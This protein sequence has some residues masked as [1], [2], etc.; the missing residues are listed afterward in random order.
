M[1][2]RSAPGLDTGRLALLLAVL[3]R[4]VGLSLGQRRR[5]RLGR[6][7]ASGSAEPGADLALCLAL[8]SAARRPA[9]ARRPGRL[10]RGRPGRRGPPG[11][12]D[13]RGGW[14]RRP[15][16]GSAG[17]W[18]RVRRRPTAPARGDAGRPRWPRRCAAGLVG[19]R[20]RPPAARV[21]RPAP[22]AGRRRRPRPSSRAS[23]PSR[24]GA[25]EP[26]D[27]RPG[28]RP[29]T[30]RGVLSRPSAP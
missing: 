12:P 22:P 17:P 20:G 27:D 5:L 11:G 26:A 8:A 18:S 19:R 15:G 25:G 7:R 21:R 9:A 3:E 24:L 1:P 16:S 30:H 6:R 28:V 29:S 4:R 14:P 2:R 10:R 13:R 23:G